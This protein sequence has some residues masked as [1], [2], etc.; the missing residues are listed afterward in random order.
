[1]QRGLPHQ[2]TLLSLV[3]CSTSTSLNNNPSRGSTSTKVHETSP[4]AMEVMEVDS[5]PSAD[6]LNLF[7]N[8]AQEHTPPAVPTPSSHRKPHLATFSVT[9]NVQSRTPQHPLAISHT[10]EPAIPQWETIS[11]TSSR[12]PGPKKPRAKP[13]TDR[14]PGH[15]LLSLNKVDSIVHADRKRHF[16]SL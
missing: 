6:E 5:A 7:G 14:T 16:V 13:P 15:T 3:S 1:M 8:S 9:S 10:A 12:A 11:T 4:P 2:P